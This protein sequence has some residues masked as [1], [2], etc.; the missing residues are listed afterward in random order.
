VH[1]VASELEQ[2]EIDLNVTQDTVINELM[3]HLG[4]IG[5][6]DQYYFSKVLS[7]IALV[8]SPPQPFTN[9]AINQVELAKILIKDSEN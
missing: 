9:K 8:L 6:Y 5:E 1:L 3:V 4:Q 2:T 7:F